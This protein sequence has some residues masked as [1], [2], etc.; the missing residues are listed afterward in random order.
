MRFEQIRAAA[1]AALILG[2]AG[3]TSPGDLKLGQADNWGEAN[4]QTFAAQVINPSPEYDTALAPSS[5][6]HAAQAV[7]RYR[8][9]KVKQPVKQSL[10]SVGSKSGTGS[11]SSPSGGN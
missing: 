8:S 11:G 6:E 1:G 2:A 4:R 7:E 9:D 10:S 5:G 3:C